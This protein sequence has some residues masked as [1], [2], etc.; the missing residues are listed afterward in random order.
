MTSAEHTCIE[1]KERLD[2]LA[3]TLAIPPE[4]FSA[5]HAPELIT[6]RKIPVLMD[7]GSTKT[8]DA[9]RVLYSSVRGPGKGGFRYHPEVDV[10]EVSVLAFL[11]SLKCA[12]VDIPFGGA[13]GGVAVNPKELSDDELERLTRSFVREMFDVIGPE[14]DI[15]APDVNTN[16][17]IMDWF[18]DEYSLKAGKPTPAIVTGKPIVSGGS[19]GRE[20]ATSLG[21]AFVLKRYVEK[22]GLSPENTKVAIQGLGN[23]G[24]HIARILDTWGYTIVAVSDSKH[25]IYNREGL[26]V[27]AVLDARKNKESITDLP[28]ATVINNDTLLESDVDVLIPAALAHQIT[29][30]NAD[31]IKARVILE[32]ANAPIAQDAEATLAQKNCVVLPDILANAGGV[33]VSYYEW[34]QNMHN[35]TWSEEKVNTRLE[36][37]IVAAFDRVWEEVSQNNLDFRTASYSIATQTIAKASSQ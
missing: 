9:Y 11:M 31:R 34:Y 24:G 4:T 16:A 27:A 32:M 19:L 21:G 10:D 5:L 26:D 22:K 20:T 14:K 13:K 17:Q 2:T 15:P 6:K 23:V 33:I 1:C 12:L 8:F 30:K 18:L 7:D 36:E 29:A 35:E 3:E 25:A 28:N 37:K